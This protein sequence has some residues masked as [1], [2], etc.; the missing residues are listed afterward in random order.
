MSDALDTVAAARQH[1]AAN[2]H[3]TAN[4]LY[5]NIVESAS[6]SSEP[7][8]RLAC[9]NARFHLA[10]ACFDGIV[11]VV[12]SAPSFDGVVIMWFKLCTS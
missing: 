6:D 11:N 7:V 2:E 4:A 8:D 9:I 5:Q 1:G 10:V 12:Y 3:D